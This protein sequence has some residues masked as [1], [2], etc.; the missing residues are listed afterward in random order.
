MNRDFWRGR[1][2]LI[3]GVTGFKGSWLALWLSRLGAT[4]SGYALP[5]PTEPS[6]FERAGI[7]NLID[8]TNG[9]VRSLLTL[10]RVMADKKPEVV[11]HLAAQPIV[12]TSYERPV[13][14]FETNIMG[15]VNVLEASRQCPATKVVVVVTSDKCYEDQLTQGGYR[16][17]DRLGGHDPY[18]TSKACAELVAAAYQKSLLGTDGPAVVTARAGNV[19]GGGDWARDR[20]VPDVVTALAADRTVVIRNPRCVRP[21][22]HVLDPLAGYLLLTERAW[23]SKQDFNS[24]WNFGPDADST[25]PVSC[26]V[27]DL[28]RLWGGRAHWEHDA[29]VQPHE[30]LLLTLDSGKA[31][32]KLGWTP[33]LPYAEALEWTAEWYRFVLGGGEARSRTVRQIEQYEE[34]AA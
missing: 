7:G 15:T 8:W 32:S 19:I 4:V 9:D 28:C 21:W 13:E 11:I 24:A 20:L 10:G 31:R 5:P 34:R 29:S 26:V 18:A 6:L 14:T 1:R 27:D 16:E 25:Q 33:Q 22:Q 12:R 3:T 30:T 2:V 17:G 23:Q